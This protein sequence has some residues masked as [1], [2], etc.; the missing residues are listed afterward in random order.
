MTPKHCPHCGTSLPDADR[1]PKVCANPDCKEEV[2]L[3]PIPAA[4]LVV[5]VEGGGVLMI[6]RN[7]N[8][9]HGEIGIPG[10]Y[11]DR[12]ETWEQCASREL[13]EETGVV[14]RERDVRLF[15]VLSYPPAPLVLY[16][17]SM[18]VLKPEEIPDWKC[19]EC[20]ETLVIDKP[21]PTAFRGHDTVL[22]QFFRIWTGDVEAYLKIIDDGAP[23]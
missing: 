5:P 16:G 6:R 8:P 3:N 13:W 2:F 21:T 19:E 7:I 22:D 12:H 18:R 20:M 23:N 11:M 4:N 15:M 1:W 14:V 17:A 10:G 9:G